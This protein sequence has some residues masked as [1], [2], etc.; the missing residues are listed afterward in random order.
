M[1]MLWEADKLDVET[2][3]D[4]SDGLILVSGMSGRSLL[5]ANH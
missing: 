5:V 1:V 3:T 2:G 4:E